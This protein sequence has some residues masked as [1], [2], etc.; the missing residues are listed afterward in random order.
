[1]WPRGAIERGSAREIWLCN[2]RI[3]VHVQYVLL[4]MILLYLNY[5]RRCM[6][7]IKVQR[8]AVSGKFLKNS[9]GGKYKFKPHISCVHTLL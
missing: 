2:T 3:H 7:H 4:I 8:R 6:I 9:Y 1:M 5:L